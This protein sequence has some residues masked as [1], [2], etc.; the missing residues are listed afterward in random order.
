MLRRK[1]LL[2]QYDWWLPYILLPSSFLLLMLQSG[3]MSLII[4]SVVGGPADTPAPLPS[5]LEDPMS[6]SGEG[7]R[8]GSD[9]DGALPGVNL[10]YS[11]VA[12]KLCSRRTPT[13]S[14]IPRGGSFWS[15]RHPESKLPG[16][17]WMTWC[18]ALLLWMQ[19]SWDVVMRIVSSHL[20][21]AQ[22]GE[23]KS[24]LLFVPI[25]S[26]LNFPIGSRICFG[27]KNYFMESLYCLYM[28]GGEGWM[29]AELH[30]VCFI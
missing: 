25:W 19:T 11:P 13:L 4:C 23:V 20:I 2:L 9:V 15:C 8:S 3:D 1:C 18:L 17:S 5:P 16:R 24:W 14:Q 22:V 10:H 7:F 12:L 30:G 26:R 29:T 28:K 6:L 27:N 21:Y